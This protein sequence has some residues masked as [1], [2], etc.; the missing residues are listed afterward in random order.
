MSLLFSASVM[1]MDFSNLSNQ[2]KEI[3]EIGINRLHYDIMDGKFVPN[4]TLGFDMIKDITKISTLPIDVHLMI[5]NPS[6]FINILKN[7]QVDSITFHV[8]NT[9]NEAFR[10]VELIHNNNIKAGIAL[11]PLTPITLIELILGRLDFITIMTVDPG[12]AGQQ[13]I[14]ETLKKIDFLRNVKEKNNYSY[15]IMID[16]SVNLKTLPTIMK[17][18]PDILILGN[19]GLFG[20]PEGLKA[21]FYKI[22]NIPEVKNNY[23]AK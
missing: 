1:C 11:S 7:Y 21:T 20:N 3:E 14:P 8:E 23:G 10:I 19:S 9:I 17:H 12:F 13:F 6:K 22:T 18:L 4:I 15:S 16:G 5:E 2:L